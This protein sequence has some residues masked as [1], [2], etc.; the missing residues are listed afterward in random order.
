MI[1]DKKPSSQQADAPGGLDGGAVAWPA[2]DSL[3]AALQTGHPRI[4]AEHAHLLVSMRSLKT[5]CIDLQNLAS[6]AGC[7]DDR[8]QRCEDDLVGILGDLLAFILEHFEGEERV[9]RE[10]LLM[11]VDRAV[12]EA[13]MEDHAAISG[14]IQEIVA[15]LNLL[16]TVSRIRELDTLLERWIVNHIQLHD[17]FLAHWVD[18]QRLGA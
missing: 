10:T 15:S 6:C 2:T 8:R 1:R 14:K 3:P 11:Q 9:M 4:D 5:I 12:C 7:G 16:E 18:R 17:V 13:H